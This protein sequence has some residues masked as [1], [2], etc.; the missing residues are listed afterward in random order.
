MRLAL[1]GQ[2]LYDFIIADLEKTNVKINVPVIDRVMTYKESQNLEH[3][4]TQLTQRTVVATKRALDKLLKELSREMLVFAI[5][6]NFLS[7]PPGMDR[8]FIKLIDDLIIPNRDNYGDIVDNAQ[9]IGFHTFSDS[10]AEAAYM[11]EVHNF[12][13]WAIVDFDFINVTCVLTVGKNLKDH[14]HEIK[15]GTGR[16]R[17]EQYF[18]NG[19]SDIDIADEKQ[20]ENDL[21]Q[22]VRGLTV[23]NDKAT[24]RQRPGAFRTSVRRTRKRR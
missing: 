11:L 6:E 4:Y 9:S 22:T 14:L 24:H 20:L 21:L 5:Y 19:S 7:I 8:L 23:K 1:D 3:I 13:R 12:D 18:P 16:W 10:L 15:Y 17:G 2:R